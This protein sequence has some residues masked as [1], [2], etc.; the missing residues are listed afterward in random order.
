[1]GT[2]LVEEPLTEKEVIAPLANLGCR[3]DLGCSTCGG[4][5]II[6]ITKSKI[7]DSEDLS[8]MPDMDDPRWEVIISSCRCENE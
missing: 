8:K 4:N 5:I 6:G 2:K 3:A 1:M 7:K